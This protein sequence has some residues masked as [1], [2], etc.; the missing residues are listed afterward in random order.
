MTEPKSIVNHQG[1]GDNYIDAHIII[2][3]IVKGT[4][5]SLSLGF[6]WDCLGFQGCQKARIADP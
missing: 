4:S 6:R 3:H 1:S 5:C 2:G